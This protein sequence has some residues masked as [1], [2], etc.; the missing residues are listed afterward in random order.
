[1]Y[2][3]H[4]LALSHRFEYTSSSSKLSETSYNS[5]NS[6]TLSSLWKVE[7]TSRVVA[8]DPTATMARQTSLRFPV[9]NEGEMII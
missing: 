4:I 8:S 7:E 3:V 6:A 9:K 2:R 1:V 5:L